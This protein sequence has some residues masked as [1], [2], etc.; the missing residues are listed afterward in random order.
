MADARTRVYITVDVECAEERVDGDTKSP[1]MGYDLR[2]WGRFVN[3]R[4]PLGI[5]LI[6]REL[7]ACGQR[8]TFFVEAIGSYSFG[9]DGLASVCQALH[10]RGHDV[11]LHVH[12]VQRRADWHTRGEPRISD[13]IADYPVEEQARLLVEGRDLLVRAGIPAG[14]LLGYRAGNFG[15]SNDTWRAMK[16]AGLVLSSNYNPCYFKKNCKMQYPGARLGL[17]ETPEEGVYELPITNFIEPTRRFRHLQITAVT[18]DEIKHCLMR[19]RALGVREVTLVTHSFEFYFLDSAS[20]RRGH[21]NRLNMDR[22]RGL[23]RFLKESSRDFEVDTVGSLARRLAE[24]APEDRE[25]APPSLQFP[26]SNPIHHAR[27]VV[28]QAYKRVAQRI[29]FG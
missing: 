8:G 10:G 2:I 6:M 15:A 27:R 23:C 19:Y 29:T 7:E 20:A 1:A 28:E 25:S 14:E 13:D 3:Q 21:P 16:R 5:E 24:A 22:L 9:M 11:Q 17:F 4:E 12:P 26:T 18:L